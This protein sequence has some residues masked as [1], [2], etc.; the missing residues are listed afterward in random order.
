MRAI[1]VKRHD[2]SDPVACVLS[3]GW[4][5]CLQDLPRGC[6]VYVAVR[7]GA[8]W[9]AR[10]R[11]AARTNEL[12]ADERRT[13]M[14]SE[15]AGRLRRSPAGPDAYSFDHCGRKEDQRGCY[16]TQA[17]R[18]ER[19]ARFRSDIRSGRRWRWIET[20]RFRHVMPPEDLKI[21]GV[22]AEYP[23]DAAD[24][25][26]PSHRPVSGSCLCCMDLVYH[27]C[28]LVTCS[29]AMPDD[30]C[31]LAREGGQDERLGQPGPGDRCGLRLGDRASALVIRCPGPEV[32]APSGVTALPSGLCVRVLLRRA[33]RGD[34]S[35][36]GARGGRR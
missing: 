17:H 15:L 27:G 12:D 33:C 31:R 2:G 10:S 13:I 28:W 14:D 34:E 24:P 19:G 4:P 22:P 16:G 3:P 20:K 21:D 5:D 23:D 25:P 36:A 18:Y 30:R 11:A 35:G 29:S 9:S 26:Q 32:G 6:L 1:D 7:E 8:S